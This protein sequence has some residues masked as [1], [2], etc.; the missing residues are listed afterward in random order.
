MQLS[1]DNYVDANVD[2]EQCRVGGDEVDD[3]LFMEA[4][5]IKY[6]DQDTKAPCHKERLYSS[7]SHHRRPYKL[8]CITGSRMS[9]FGSSGRGGWRWQRCNDVKQAEAEEAAESSDETVVCWW[10]G[11]QQQRR[12]QLRGLKAADAGDGSSWNKMRAATGVRRDST[13]DVEQEQ[14]RKT[15]P[16]D[17]DNKEGRDSGDGRRRLAAVGG[18][19]AAAG[20][21]AGCGAVDDSRGGCRGITAAGGS[22]GRR[23]AMKRR[24]AREQR[25]Q[26]CGTVGW[27]AGDRGGAGGKRATAAS[28]RGEGAGDVAGQRHRRRRLAAMAEE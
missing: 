2:I 13:A 8:T 27:G 14:G 6:K 17:A 21:T 20:A 9:Q 18:E 16:R 4:G 7:M 25:R 26:A 11:R 28:G 10:R 22:N 24:G 1:L 15:A 23:R 12:L 3:A 5:G 19:T